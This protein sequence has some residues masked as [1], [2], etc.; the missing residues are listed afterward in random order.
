MAVGLQSGITVTIRFLN[1]DLSAGNP[2]STTVDLGCVA[3]VKTSYAYSAATPIL[4]SI[5]GNIGMS[6]TTRQA[7]EYAYVSP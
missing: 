2:C 7:V 1:A 6:S 5:V 3:E 4:S